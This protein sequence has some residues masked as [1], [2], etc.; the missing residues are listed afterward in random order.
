MFPDTGIRILTAE[1]VL[2]VK[3]TI[4]AA[5]PEL[6]DEKRRIDHRRCVTA[7]HLSSTRFDGT[8]QCEFRFQ[9]LSCRCFADIRTL[10]INMGITLLNNTLRTQ[11][12]FQT[13]V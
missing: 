11:H 12:V 3:E 6:P 8:I 13:S 4:G 1:D 7:R 9:F 5:V 2:A 10:R